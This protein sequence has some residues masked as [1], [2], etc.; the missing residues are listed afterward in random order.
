MT[1]RKPAGPKN[2]NAARH[3]PDTCWLWCMSHVSVVYAAHALGTSRQA[4]FQALERG[5]LT[6]NQH[7][8]LSGIHVEELR[9]FRD[10]PTRRPSGPRVK[11]AKKGLSTGKK[12]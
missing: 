1:Q 11:K 5:T 10:S 7:G 9:K 2:T 4:V 3:D 12:P 6:L 8:T